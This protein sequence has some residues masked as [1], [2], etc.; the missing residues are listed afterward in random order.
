MYSGVVSNWT[1]LGQMLKNDLW[2]TYFKLCAFY[3][4]RAAD[5]CTYHVIV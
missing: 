4:S 1:L 5:A 3:I 2:L